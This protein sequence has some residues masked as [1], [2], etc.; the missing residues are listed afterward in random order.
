MSCHVGENDGAKSVGRKAN[1]APVREISGAK[2]VVNSRRPGD[3]KLECSKQPPWSD[4]LDR[5]GISGHGAAVIPQSRTRNGQTRSGRWFGQH[6][7]GQR[8]AIQNECRSE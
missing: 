2:N 1:S 3:S 4:R 7:G 8:V 5:Q 6:E